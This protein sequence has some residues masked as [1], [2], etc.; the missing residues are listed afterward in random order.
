MTLAVAAIHEQV[1]SIP[2]ELPQ[3]FGHISSNSL[4]G[5]FFEDVEVFADGAITRARFVMNEF[6]RQRRPWDEAKGAEWVRTGYI[7]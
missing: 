5:L 1:I 4:L 3:E 2:A 7:E 6:W